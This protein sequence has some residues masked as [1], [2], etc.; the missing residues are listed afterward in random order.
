MA[1]SHHKV[2]MQGLDR[3]YWVDLLFLKSVSGK[4]GQK[5]LEEL[6]KKRCLSSETTDLPLDVACTHSGALLESDLFKFAS[7]GAQGSIRAAADVCR[8]YEEGSGSYTASESGG[9]P[10]RGVVQDSHVLLH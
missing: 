6:F 9:I 7:A 1:L 10:C 3:F 4:E 8:K 5:R 2:K